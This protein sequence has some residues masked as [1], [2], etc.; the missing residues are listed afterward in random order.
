MS[1]EIIKKIQRGWCGF[2][3]LKLYIKVQENTKLLNV[4]SSIQS[5]QSVYYPGDDI[6]MGDLGPYEKRRTKINKSGKITWATNFREKV[7]GQEEKLLGKRADKSSWHCRKSCKTEVA[8][9]QTLS[10]YSR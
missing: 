10:T 7:D 5:V 8:M 6:Q 9:N 2:G 3:N 1:D 4:Q